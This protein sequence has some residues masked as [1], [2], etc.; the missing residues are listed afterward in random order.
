MPEAGVG[1][2]KP[3]DSPFLE[4]PVDGGIDDL[5]GFRLQCRIVRVSQP[6]GD[7]IRVVKWLGEEPAVG[8]GPRGLPGPVCADHNQKCRSRPP[9]CHSP[10][11][12]GR[13]SVRLIVPCGGCSIRYFRSS[14]T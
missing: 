12:S 9:S 7:R 6:L 2:F 14:E 10:C 11:D 8:A 13:R 5:P 3:E 4:I 1:T